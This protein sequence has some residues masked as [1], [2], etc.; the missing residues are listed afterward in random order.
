[1]RWVFVSF[2][3]LTIINMIWDHRYFVLR[4]IFIPQV[5]KNL[6]INPFDLSVDHLGMHVRGG[7]GWFRITI[8]F[9]FGNFPHPKSPYFDEHR[10]TNQHSNDSMSS[11]PGRNKLIYEYPK[12][13]E[14]LCPI[15]FLKNLYWGWQFTIQIQPH[16]RE[17][18]QRNLPQNGQFHS[19]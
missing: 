14:L 12:I 13:F 18:S 15:G 8:D 3:F 17:S 19:R 1:M 11:I 9:P 5:F 10:R 6:E 16:W 4:L 7:F 2:W